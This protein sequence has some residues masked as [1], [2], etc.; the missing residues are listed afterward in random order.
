MSSTNDLISQP[1]CD[2]HPAQIRRVLACISFPF[3]GLIRKATE[4]HI[5]ALSRL[6]VELEICRLEV[7][8]LT[9][10]TPNLPTSYI[11]ECVLPAENSV[12]LF[13]NFMM[14]NRA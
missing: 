2:R 5:V 14:K 1:R 3:T 12:Y 11:E 6:T 7:R 13:I 9:R 4:Q 10:Y 8:H